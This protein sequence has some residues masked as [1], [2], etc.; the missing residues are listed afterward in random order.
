MF[1]VRSWL[2]VETN[3]T[4]RPF[5]PRILFLYLSNTRY[6]L[7]FTSMYHCKQTNKQTSSDRL[8]A[9]RE[10]VGITSNLQRYA[11]GCI[12]SRTC[13]LTVIQSLVTIA[14]YIFIRTSHFA[15]SSSSPFPQQQVMAPRTPQPGLFQSKSSQT[16][17]ASSNAPLVETQLQR[18]HLLVHRDAAIAATENMAQDAR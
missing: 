5:R 18:R 13:K 11:A 17:G 14:Y 7:S 6:Q 16:A 15:L 3:I 1:H 10:T 9:N 4:R 8:T 12:L 2:C